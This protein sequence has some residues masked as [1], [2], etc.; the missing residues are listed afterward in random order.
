MNFGG[1]LYR[2]R[3]LGEVVRGTE[4]Q[5]VY[6]IEIIFP[7][8]PNSRVT[9]FS[10]LDDNRVEMSL[11]EVPDEKIIAPFV[12]SLSAANPKLGFALQMIEHRF[13]HGFLESRLERLF[14]PKIILIRRGCSEEDELLFRENERADMDNASVRS[15]TGLVLRFMREAP[16]AAESDRGATADAGRGIL[17]G[18]IER[19]RRLIR[20]Q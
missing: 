9:E 7:E 13:G 19:I 1:E 2:M 20:K 15:L 3:T 12:S 14:A 5:K 18:V 10:V 16:E 8:L 4:G 11:F 17:L 6:R